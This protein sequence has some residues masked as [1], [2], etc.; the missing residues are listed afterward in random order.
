MTS[1]KHFLF[2]V[3]VTAAIGI[4][5]SQ[6]AYREQQAGAFSDPVHCDKDG[7]PSCLSGRA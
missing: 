7:W 3:L 2:I 6:V 4:G 5:V 1:N